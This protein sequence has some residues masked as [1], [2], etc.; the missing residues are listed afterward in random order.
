MAAAGD[1][2]RAELLAFLEAEHRSQLD[3]PHHTEAEADALG[4]DHD[5]CPCRF[6]VEEAA[7]YLA[8]HWHGGGGSNLYAAQCASPFKPGPS[9]DDLPDDLNNDNC[10]RYASTVLYIAGFDWIEAGCPAQEVTP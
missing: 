4:D 9:D 10:E 7:Y 2:T 3:G 5:G 8:V 6:D 1:P